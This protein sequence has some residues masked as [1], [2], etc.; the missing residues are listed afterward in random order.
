VEKRSYDVTRVEAL[1]QQIAQLEDCRRWEGAGSLSSGCRPLD[2]ILPE[3]GIRRGT[4]VEWLAQGEGSGAGTLAWLA[5]REACRSGGA[6][7]VLDA[8]RDFC[9]TAAVRMA[10]EPERLIV[11]RADTAG[12]TFWALDQALR[13]GAVAAALA[14]PEAQNGKLDGRTFRRWQLAAEESGV[15][16]LLIRPAAVRHEPSW[17]DVRLLVEPLPGVGLVSNVPDPNVPDPKRRRLRIHLLRCRGMGDRRNVD[18]ELDDET[19]PVHL[20]AQLAD[21]APGRYL[22]CR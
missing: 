1:R 10:I 7:V 2:D 17:A 6:V 22:G 15:L 12:D 21:P 11:V 18:V 4:L 3:R 13:C 9:P 14:W 20:A 8:R 16:G 19:L 5:A